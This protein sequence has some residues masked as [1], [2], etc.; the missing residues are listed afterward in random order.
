M[1]KKSKVQARELDSL[2][3]E[4]HALL[5]TCLEESTR[6]RPGLF[7]QLDRFPEYQK[8]FKWAEAERLGEL[9][10]EI[11]SVRAEF[12]TSN[13]LCDR[14]LQLRSHRDSNSQGEM[15]LARLLLD[16]LEV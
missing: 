8:W 6:G 9:A 1:S 12:G 10:L 16:E 11:Q 4:F 13:S 3:V 14:F 5:T 7:G 15:K 2:E